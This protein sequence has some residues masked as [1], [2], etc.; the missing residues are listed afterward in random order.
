MVFNVI[1][2]SQ[3]YPLALFYFQQNFSISKSYQI[4]FK[5]LLLF[6]Y[7]YF[8]FKSEHSRRA[9]IRSKKSLEI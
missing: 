1:H 3:L 4:S 9:A 7:R 6:S 5:F 8:V 2:Y